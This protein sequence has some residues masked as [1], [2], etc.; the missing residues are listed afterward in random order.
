M[1]VFVGIYCLTYS[2]FTS[3]VE[4]R[5]GFLLDTWFAYLAAR[6]AIGNRDTLIRSVKTVSLVL[7]PLA[8]LGIVEATTGW[9]PFAALRQ[10]CLWR[11][12]IVTY[13]P[14]WGLTRAWGPFSHPIMFASSFVIF[15]P[16]IWALR[17]QRNHWG[18]LS[19]PL[20]GMAGCGAFSTMS[21]ASWAAGIVAVFC[22]AM[23]R[24]K[25]WVKPLLIA[26]VILCIVTEIVSKR[27]FYHAMYERANLGGGDW[28]QRATLIDAAIE[29]VDEWWLA[30]YG[31]KYHDWGPGLYDT[32]H[33]V[34]KAGIQYGLLGIIA[35]CAVLIEVFR[36]LSSA[37]RK[38]ADTELK[39]VYWSL[40]STVLSV[41]VIWQG[42]SFFGTPLSLF[43]SI[44]GMTASSLA[45]VE[46][47]TTNNGT[48]LRT[49]NVGL[50]CGT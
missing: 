11:S 24:F 50:I 1:A 5:A 17:H 38:T 12:A 42:V 34:I 2:P 39:S 49:D 35:L 14:R 45:F 23:E 7:A 29:H 16:L 21:S 4:S 27:P 36:G 41:I 46:C 48:L 44:L 28:Y 40:G 33:E 15:L 9:Q 3:A 30:G 19:Y 18:K 8:I 10:Y 37:S 22:L 43:Y 47:V 6:F 13:G 32:N 26:F 31:G 20:V 25:R